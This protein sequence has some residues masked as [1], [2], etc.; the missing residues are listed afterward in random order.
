MSA[1]MIGIIGIA[2]FLLILFT[3]FPV[4]FSMFA[5]GII[6]IASLRNP[7]TAFSVTTD[8]IVSTFSSF[9]MTVAPMFILMGTIAGYSGLGS[10]LVRTA[11][12]F[13]GHRRGGLASAVQVV[14]AIF[15]AICGSMP[16][17]IAT[18]GG[19]AYP[20]M[21]RLGYS[22]RL[23]TGAICAG[24]TLAVLIPPSL[25]FI[26]YGIATQESIGKLFASGFL[27]GFVLM[28]IYIITV[29]IWCKIDPSI[30]P[31]IE[32]VPWDERWKALRSGGIVEVVIVFGISMGGLF[33]GVFTPTEAG[34]VGVFAMLVVSLVTRK[35]SFGS[36][37]ASLR[38]TIRLTCFIYFLIAG[39]SVYGKFFSLTQIPV[40]LARWLTSQG[41]SAFVIM[42]LITIIYW[43]LSF[44]VDIQ[45]LVLL[46]I[47]IFYPIV[48]QVGF[49]GIWFGAYTVVVVGIG[50]LT[51][52][53][54]L[55]TYVMH[56]V[57]KQEVPLK[58]IFI[59]VV[60]F[61]IAGFFM[62]VLLVLFPGIATFIPNMM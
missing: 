9:T 26:I 17:T 60:P 62:L 24:S 20:E 39:A 32:R 34:A 10:K 15:G 53:V 6:G 38:E 40:V 23:S 36:F 44:V 42:L 43:V 30:A 49:D 4:S 37:I 47:P 13:V 18:V 52:P 27:T 8:S 12:M 33:S 58:Q 19:M 28:V 61:M 22:D 35:L 21:K 56:G 48:I 54:A 14:C 51:P 16:A 31:K 55:L 41:F 50:G 57:T 59:G 11:N 45:A 5:V 3:G 46:T 1:G 7:S 25:T 29:T 2:V